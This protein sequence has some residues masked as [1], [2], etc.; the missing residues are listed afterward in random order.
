MRVDLSKAKALTDAQAERLA[1]EAW[2]LELQA[3]AWEDYVQQQIQR[4]WAYLQREG[5]A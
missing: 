3:E 1:T 4:M 5:L 2:Y